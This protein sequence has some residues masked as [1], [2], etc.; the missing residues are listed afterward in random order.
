[1]FI[2]SVMPCNHLIL[3]CRLLLLPSIFLS[4]RVFSNESALCIR[5]LKYSFEY[6]ISPSMNMQDWLPLGWTGWISLQSKRLSR[7]F[8]N[9]TVQSISSSA[10]NFLY[11]SA[12]TPIHGYWKN[13]SF[14]YMDLCWQ[15]NS[16]L[17]NML[18][19]F[20]VTF[21][22]RSKCLLISW[23]QSPSAVMKKEKKSVTVSIVSPPVCHEVM[24]PDAMS[25]VFW[26]L[27]FKPAFSPSSFTF[28]KKL[29]S[30]SSFS[31]IRV[32][33]SVYLRLL[34]FLLA[35]LVPACVSSS[36]AFCMMYSL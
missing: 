35:I 22:P 15:S 9:T 21:L 8:S 18:S 29:F 6:F 30:S 4:I 24:G 11:G 27:N 16:L 7:V 32:V 5:W 31:A 26:K 20:V 28:I 1:M 36:L 25:S 23:L 12:L 13:H 2:E 3:C 19:R 33:S 34:I 10:L 17:F 14:D